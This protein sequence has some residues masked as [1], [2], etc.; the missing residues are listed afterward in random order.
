MASGVN[1][2]IHSYKDYRQQGIAKNILFSIWGF[3]NHFAWGIVSAN[4]Y[5]I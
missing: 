5:A 4:P 2:T 1:E 3:S